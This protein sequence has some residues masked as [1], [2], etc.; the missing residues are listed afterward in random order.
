[1]AVDVQNTSKDDLYTKVYSIRMNDI[2]L[3][4]TKT[5]ATYYKQL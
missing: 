5:L 2:H 3:E 1:M 4:Y